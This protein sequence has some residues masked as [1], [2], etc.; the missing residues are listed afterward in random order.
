MVQ[1]V[2]FSRNSC[3]LTSERKFR[4][5]FPSKCLV[6]WGSRAR[7]RRVAPSV[8]PD[9]RRALSSIVCADRGTA[10][11]AG[12]THLRTRR[13]GD[14]L[15]WG[16]RWY[17]LAPSRPCGRGPSSALSSLPHQL[18]VRAFCGGRRTTYIAP[19]GRVPQRARARPHTDTFYVYTHEGDLTQIR[20][21]RVRTC[22]VRSRRLCRSS[23]KEEPRPT[24]HLP[25]KHLEAP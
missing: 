1:P 9:A 14:W 24:A 16:R 3:V 6:P 15:C 12:D 25:D 18:S 4:H 8:R 7:V 5:V 17:R 2:S 10:P 23:G 13:F 21:P 20:P 19:A 11:V 22:A